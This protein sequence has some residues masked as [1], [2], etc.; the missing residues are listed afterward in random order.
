MMGFKGKSQFWKKNRSGTNLVL[1]SDSSQLAEI[2]HI[3]E[4]AIEENASDEQFLEAGLTAAEQA[5]CMLLFEIPAML[6][7]NNG[8]RAAVVHCTRDGSDELFFMVLDSTS[9][10]VS[11]VAE[12]EVPETVADF[13]RSYAGVLSL[14]AN[15][16]SLSSSRLQ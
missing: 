9:G 3:V 6:M 15:V 2:P 12:E 14:M 4:G 10:E 7:E 8:D 13:T 1:V 16:Q 11:L 5:G